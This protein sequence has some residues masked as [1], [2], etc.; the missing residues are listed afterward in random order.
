[1]PGNNGKEISAENNIDSSSLF[2]FEEN[3]IPGR[4]QKM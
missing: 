2:F 1:M 4:N 3:L